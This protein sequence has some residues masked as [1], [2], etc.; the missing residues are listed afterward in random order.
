M[1]ERLPTQD[2]YGSVV[3]GA[4]ELAQNCNGGQHAD[5]TKDVNGRV[6]HK[7]VEVIELRFLVLRCRLKLPR[8]TEKA[9][10]G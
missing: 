6:S 7:M 1:K 3:A 8:R 4:S 10:P 9:Q 2:D 5:M